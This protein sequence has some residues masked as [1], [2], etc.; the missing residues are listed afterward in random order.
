M[1]PAWKILAACLVACGFIACGDDGSSD[2][3]PDME[4][5]DFKSLP[6]CNPDNEGKTAE[7]E[8]EKA[9]Y[10]CVEGNWEKMSSSSEKKSDKS[11]KSCSSSEKNADEKDGDE[12]EGEDDSEMSAPDSSK[13]VSW[14]YLN[15]DVEYGLM[16]D[17][18]DNQFYKTVVIG[19]QKW[20]A[21]NL[22]YVT[23]GGN[24]DGGVASWCKNS[25]QD[26]CFKYGRLYTW[27][28]A[29]DKPASECGTGKVCQF[30]KQMQGLCPKGWH[31]PNNDEWQE[32]FD[33]VET[34]DKDGNE[35]HGGV[36]MTNT[37]AGETDVYGF[38]AMRMSGYYSTF[39][40]SFSDHDGEI[41]FWSASQIEPEWAEYV[42]LLD[43][44]EFLFCN[45]NMEAYYVR[46]LNDTLLSDKPIAKSSSSETIESSS[47]GEPQSVY[48]AS[49]NTLTDLR[50][51]QTYRTT[52][53]GGQVWMAENL[54]YEFKYKPE[55]AEEITFSYCG[56]G[57]SGE[58]D[59]DTYGWLYTWAGAMDS[60]GVFG[61]TGLG[62]GFYWE[63]RPIAQWVSDACE[64]EEVVRGVCPE[65]WHLPDTTEWNAL[66]EYVGGKDVANKNLI[67]SGAQT[68]DDEHS[69]EFGFSVLLAGNRLGDGTFNGAGTVAHFWS[70]T[71][72]EGA[73]E[74]HAWQ[75]QFYKGDSHV[76]VDIFEADAAYSVR[77]LKDF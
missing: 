38:S 63:H 22:N 7:V 55:D 40:Q 58:D 28:A 37:E 65:G 59:C 57:D 48:D 10:L 36:L 56:R 66:F 71:Q 70:S 3:P 45:N 44:S 20:M 31:V 72:Y 1:F 62:C 35:L 76:F 52:T 51:G 68:M 23:K 13:K 74:G 69:D 41:N 8:N 73:D 4:S 47:S 50:D 21:E 18:R 24:A 42:R 9:V 2:V 39:Y 75:M 19:R 67:T 43:W 25:S 46:C 14:D 29:M 32:L 49:A 6:L 17:S 11:G 61:N 5:Y 77:C 60:A 15:P 12:K 27:A 16:V 34:K 30:D 33:F 53:I 64:A 54:N 26:S